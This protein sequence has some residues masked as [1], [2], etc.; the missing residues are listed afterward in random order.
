[1]KLDSAISRTAASA[2]LCA[3]LCASANAGGSPRRLRLSPLNATLVAGSSQNFTA[4]LSFFRGTTELGGER[5]VSSGITRWVSSDPKVV[6]IGFDGKAVAGSPGTTTIIAESGPLHATATVTVIAPFSIVGVLPADG[7][8]Q[9]DLTASV[10]WTFNRPADPAT[11]TVNTTDTQCSGSLQLSAD[12]FATCVTMAGT[13]AAA[14]ADQTFTIVPQTP[15]AA[16]T[17]YQARVATA[18]AD[19]NGFT[20]P[21]SFLSTFTSLAPPASPT[22]VCA[23]AGAGVVTLCWNP[24]SGATGYVVLRSITSGMNYVVLAT[25][26]GT[27]F[28]DNFVNPGT[29]YFYVVEATN[30]AGASAFSAEVS[31]T[32]Q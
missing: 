15:L 1:M 26:T 24:S 12:H 7:A 2:L 23:N 11:I 31:A 5:D 30:A 14:N 27:G 25:T 32:P 9:V 4:Y 8:T 18:A 3:L 19:L 6:D 13:P 21:A 28:A 20:L 10:S 17:Q 29:T 22:G 16:A